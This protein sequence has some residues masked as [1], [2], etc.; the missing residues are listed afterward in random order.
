[1]SQSPF[2]EIRPV[3]LPFSGT[4][5]ASGFFS[6]ETQ[7]RAAFWSNVKVTALCP[8]NPLWLVR[9]GGAPA[10]PGI[11]A[12]TDMGPFLVAPG[13]KVKLT[14]TSG[15][16]LSKVEGSFVGIQG[17]LAT[18]AAAYAP[19]PNTVSLQ[20]SAQQI[21]LDTINAKNDGATINH[22]VTLPPGTH[23]LALITDAPGLLSS[24]TVQG[25]V[26][27]IQ[28][29]FATTSQTFPIYGVVLQALDPTVN[30]QVVSV[31]TGGTLTYHVWLVA[32]LDPLAIVVEPGT[33][34]NV[35]L[36]DPSNTNLALQ[37][38]ASANPGVPAVRR[39]GVSLQNAIA[40]PWQAPTSTKS[41]AISATGTVDIVPAVA[42][43]IIRI[44]G[45]W[46]QVD[47]G[48]GNSVCF[49]E[50]NGGT[51]TRYAGL[52]APASTSFITGNL[53]GAPVPAGLKLV[54]DA[55]ILGTGANLRGSVAFS[56]SLI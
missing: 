3:E 29:V 47:L 33:P 30:F 38:D 48:T 32:I 54:L 44:F 27:T 31:N 21:L 18:V 42:N 56:Q 9:V 50:D 16:P 10:A 12:Q 26:S 5:D 20:A 45:Y 55:A 24:S 6:F 39:Q 46:M 52:V 51:V 11:G 36:F 37:T 53:G 40:A 19:T 4:T 41:A 17:D 14:V 25:N 43:Q 35:V 23:S 1:V 49:L 15:T 13:E 8:G 34:L 7:I 28:Y 2:A 22:T